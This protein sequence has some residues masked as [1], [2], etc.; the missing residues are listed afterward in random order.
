MNRTIPL[1]STLCLCL[2]ILAPGPE[3]LAQLQGEG[4]ARTSL[5]GNEAFLDAVRMEDVAAARSLLEAGANPN[6]GDLLGRA[7]HYATATGDLEMIRLLL[8]QDADID[9]TDSNG[10]TALFLSIAFSHNDVARLLIREGANLEATTD[11]GDRAIHAAVIRGNV[12]VIRELL[13]AGARI[14]DP[15][16]GTV[17]VEDPA[18]RSHPIICAVTND[19]ALAFETLYQADR[20]RLH[21]SPL[22]SDILT[23]AIKYRESKWV[24]RLM[25]G[26][27]LDRPDPDGYTPLYHAAANTDLGLVKALLE[28]GAG[29]DAP[30]RHGQTPLLSSISYLNGASRP[31]EN[32]EGLELVEYLIQQGADVNVQLEDDG[33]RPL[34]IAALHGLYDITRILLDSGA[35]ANP[36]NHDGFTPESIAEHFQYLEISTLLRTHD[37]THQSQV[38]D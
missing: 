2:V 27:D 4:P 25:E 18:A 20:E 11:S 13:A 17:R 26:A 22:M 29:V 5:A 16:D 1:L 37:F 34:H 9:A 21:G 32:V 10:R 33:S 28:A 31:D 8:S 24:A 38:T 19:Q 7:I 14:D 35:E 30:S 3:T 12:A 6:S 15:V 23:A 36:S